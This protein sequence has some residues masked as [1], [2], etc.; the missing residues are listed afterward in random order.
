MRD[1]PSRPPPLRW[2]VE[3]GIGRDGIGAAVARAFEESRSGY[4]MGRFLQQLPRKKYLYRLAMRNVEGTHTD[5]TFTFSD[6]FCASLKGTDE[7]VADVLH[8]II[9]TPWVGKLWGEIEQ[10][11][12]AV[13]CGA[14]YA[15]ERT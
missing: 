1:D 10:V 2:I 11:T 13:A 3:H 7:A 15:G 9:K 5:V 6:G 14:T 8:K 12:E 4:V